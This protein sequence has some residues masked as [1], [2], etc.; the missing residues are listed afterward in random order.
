MATTDANIAV[1]V[2]ADISPLKRDMKKAKRELSGFQSHAKRVGSALVTIGA[3]AAAA[4]AGFTAMA[5]AAG[6]SAKE[7]QTLATI[8]G[9][10]VEAFQRYARTAKTVGIQQEQLGDI[11]K[12]TNEKLGEFIA[13]GGGGFKDF[14]DRMQ[15]DISDVRTAFAGLSGPQVLG[16]MKSMLEAA[17]VPLK[18][19]VFFF[20]S[21]ASESSKLIPI[22]GELSG[23][24]TG[25][26]ASMKSIIL[27]DDEVEKLSDMGEA[28]SNLGDTFS[29][30]GDRILAAV[31]P[32]L[33][34]RIKQL[35]DGLVTLSGETLP[36]VKQAADE[37]NESMSRFARDED[38]NLV[39]DITQGNDPDTILTNA[40]EFLDR[41]H[42]VYETGFGSITDLVHRHMG[43]QG[44][45]V[46][47]SLQDMANSMKGQ[48]R[49]MFEVDKAFKIANAVITGYE[50]ATSAWSFGMKVGGPPAA[51][52]FTAASIA[53]TA[54]LVNSIRSTSFNGGGGGGGSAG[55]GGGA[56]STPVAAQPETPEN[57]IVSI[58]LEGEVFGREQI[59]GLIGQI[60]DALDDGYSLR[61][62]Q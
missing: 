30:F 2:G 42:G 24:A 60:N 35:N 3:G 25:V 11:F 52:A 31:A 1:R 55:A 17:N 12:D 56:A 21:V 27:S 8:S 28:L 36:A 48:S 43:Q 19:Q 15:M 37:T 59:G 46:V 33:T 10:G 45:I 47:S 41:L 49:K 23:K 14:A 6:N 4:G 50:A 22:F 57:T 62:Q 51:A 20:E 61:V 38:G 53:R 26:A 54:M 7:I 5:I 9:V 18:Q 13:T 16:K 32:S 34:K 29:G 58:N 44:E 39:F 40:T